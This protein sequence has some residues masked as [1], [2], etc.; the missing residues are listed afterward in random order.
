VREGFAGHR[1]LLRLRGRID[2]LDRRIVRLLCRRFDLV[3]LA[4][5]CKRSPG[6]AAA[7]SRAARV[8]NNARALAR[9]Y[10]SDPSPIAQVYR[11][12]IRIG[13]RLERRLILRRKIV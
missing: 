3:R 11:E 1:E 9:K 2:D 5:A 13:V 7:P 4:A 8:I 10:R 6:A 12:M